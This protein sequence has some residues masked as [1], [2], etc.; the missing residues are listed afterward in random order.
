MILLSAILL[1]GAIVSLAGVPIIPRVEAANRTISLVGFVLAW[2]NT[3]VP[4]PTITVTQGDV[5]TLKLSSGDAIFHQWFVD[6]DKNGPAPDCPGLDICSVAFST[7]V[8]LT[9]TVSF[10]PGTYTYYCVLHP[11]S[12]LGQFIVNPSPAVGGVA[13]PPNKLALIAPYAALAS[14][15]AILVAVAA[16][17]TRARRK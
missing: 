2:N 6:V 8:M 12:M 1:G 15:L 3:S 17:F 14:A 7:S 11:T 10:A 9:F 5:I 4:N 13:L 16:Y